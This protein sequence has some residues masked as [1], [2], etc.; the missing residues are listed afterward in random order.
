MPDCG[1]LFDADFEIRWRSAIRLNPA[2]HDGAVLIG[3]SSR[4][5]QYVIVGWSQRLFPPRWGRDAQMNRGSAFN[6]CLAMSALETI[7]AIYL[8]SK[9]EV[10]RFVRGEARKLMF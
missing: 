9:R 1:I 3:R 7:D 10:Y 4:A 6:S 8:T 2:I 5:Q